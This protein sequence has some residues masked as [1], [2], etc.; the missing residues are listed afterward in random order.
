MIRLALLVLT[1][2][3]CTQSSPDTSQL[4]LDPATG[5]MCGQLQDIA[6]PVCVYSMDELVQ[7]QAAGAA[8]VSVRG[9]LRLRAGGHVLARDN[10]DNSLAVRLDLAALPKGPAQEVIGTM[11]EVSGLYDSR[12]SPYRDD[13]A[14]YGTLQVITLKPSITGE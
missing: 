13:P 8:G 11:V 14:V 3:G 5:R 4:Q 9:Y 10:T 6:E 1:L 7:L 12:I 2:S